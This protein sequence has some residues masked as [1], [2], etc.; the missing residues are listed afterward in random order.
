MITYAKLSE[1]LALTY[2]KNTSAVDPEVDAKVIVS[3][4]TDQILEYTKQALKTIS[5]EVPLIKKQFDLTFEVDTNTYLLNDGTLSF[6]DD[7]VDPFSIEDFVGFLDLFDSNGSR[8]TIN[9]NGHIVTPTYNSI[10]FTTDKITELGEKVRIRYHSMYPEITSAS[11]IDIPPQYV[12][13]LM[14]FIAS[15]YMSHM[16]GKDSS[17]KGSDYYGMYLRKMNLNS[18]KDAGS[19]SETFTDTRLIDRGFV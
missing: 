11:E 19:V 16:N 6:M 1:Q 13:P 9:T 3:S 2:L 10:R 18:E 15:L 17:K 8:H 4:F 7:T 12:E 5:T 14:L